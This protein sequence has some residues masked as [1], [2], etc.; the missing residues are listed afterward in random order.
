MIASPGSKFNTQSDV[1]SLQLFLCLSIFS[2]Y[3]FSDCF[4]PESTRRNAAPR[5]FDALISFYV[6]DRNVGLSNELLRPNDAV[7]SIFECCA[8]SSTLSE[9]SGAFLSHFFS[10]GVWELCLNYLF[11]FFRSLLFIIDSFRVS[12]RSGRKDGPRFALLLERARRFAELTEKTY[13]SELI[14]FLFFFSLHV[15]SLG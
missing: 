5:S 2:T 14:L 9:S 1:H 11:L 6:H 12:L 4:L 13:P 15:Q 3:M 7:T 8:S 10:H